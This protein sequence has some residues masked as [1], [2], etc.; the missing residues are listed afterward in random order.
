V[1]NSSSKKT[2]SVVP[3]LPP[4]TRIYAIGDIHGRV[5]LL[6]DT[7]AR[8]DADRVRAR[9]R[10]IFEVY[11]GD[12]IDRGPGSREVLDRLI[13]RCRTHDTIFLKGNHE[14]YP[15]M[16][17]DTPAFLNNWGQLGGFETLMSYGLRPPVQTTPE[18]QISIAQ[19]FN[20]SLPSTHRRFLQ[21]LRS[22]VTC[23]DFYFV[24]AG[25]RP[26]I[27][28][29]VQREEDLLEIRDAF[30]NCEEDF[31]M[32]VVHGHTPVREPEFRP[33]RINI[34][35]GAYA[36]GRLTCLVIDGKTLRIL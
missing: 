7:L 14:T 30:L 13:E 23:G 26:G 31:G 6:N 34:D 12:Y 4:E 11:L 9:A 20:S 32:V 27:A 2:K 24:H 29:G 8:I 33:N 25:V 1:W 18:Q 5:D 22:H 35:T 17:L 28:L 3:S 36:T 15:L 21:S 19:A 16:F 10:K